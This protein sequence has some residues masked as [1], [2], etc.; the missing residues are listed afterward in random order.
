[1]VHSARDISVNLRACNIINSAAI[2]VASDSVFWVLTREI[3]GCLVLS[4]FLAYVVVLLENL[5]L[6]LLMLAGA[7]C[8]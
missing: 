8:F 7:P 3:V 1:M 4:P 2:S 6:P 5:A